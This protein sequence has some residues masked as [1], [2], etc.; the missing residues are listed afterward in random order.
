MESKEIAMN[1]KDFDELKKLAEMLIKEIPNESRNWSSHQCYVMKH[2]FSEILE[3]IG[4][5]SYR[6]MMAKYLALL[7][8]ENVL[9]LLQMIEDNKND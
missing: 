3:V 6:N 1:E 5:Y 8:P 2:D 9:N 7:S 4:V